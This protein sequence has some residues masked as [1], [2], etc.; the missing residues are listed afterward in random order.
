MPNNLKFSF[1]NINKEEFIE[2]LN[3]KG[4]YYANVVMWTVIFSLPLFWLL[5][6]LFVRD[7]WVDLMLIRLVVA[8]ISYFIYFLGGKS[9]WD[10]L[11]TIAVFVAVNL[12]MHTLFC[13][14]IPIN[15]VLP[16][17][18]MLS[19]IV[20]LLN[21][22]IFWPP[23]YS[24]LFCL[25]TYVIIFFLYSFRE[26]ADKYNLLISHGGGVYFVVSAFSCLIAY[27][28]YL[29]L[30]RE[31]GKNILINNANNRLLA[32]NEKIND[33]KYVI[34]DTNRKLKVLSDYRHNTLN[35]MLHDFRN[36]TGSI[37]MS[38]DLLKNKSD[39]L[40][41][42]QKE[43]LNYISTGNEKLN[44]LSEKLAASADRDEAKVQ[45]TKENVDI[46]P[47]VEQIVLDNADS[48]QIKQINLQLHLSASPIIVYLDKLFLDQVLFK[49]LTNVFRYAEA[50]SIVTIHTNRQ[51]DKCVIEVINIGKLIGTSKM[52]ELFT[53]I[54]PSRSLK[55]AVADDSEMG[56][57]VAKKLTE[58][59]GGTFIYNSDEKT[60]NYYRIEFTCTQ[61]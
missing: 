53:K 16:Y 61:L 21:T 35:M 43:I 8:V 25:L 9:A 24:I 34:E 52:N 40:S 10:Y 32:Q 47:I 7:Q 4:V 29:I 14:I 45:F 57:S 60:G 37:Q 15:H 31:I 56:L 11:R 46:S 12:L 13:C 49:L 3:K 26:R 48:A 55:E 23:V 30:R 51:N 1:V 59:M 44:Y 2:E 33:Q 58:T 18:L 5:D 42:E 36:F 19:I 39:N 20:L 17:F 22:A 50:G 54:H 41:V 38:L 6:F 28:R 27:N